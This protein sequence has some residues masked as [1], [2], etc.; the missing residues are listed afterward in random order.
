LGGTYNRKEAREM[1]TYDSI[2]EVAYKVYVKSGSVKGHDLDNWIEAE[3]IVWNGIEE[4][5]QC[6]LE[7]RT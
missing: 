6:A 2:E 4:E 1:I 7:L 3:R 5:T